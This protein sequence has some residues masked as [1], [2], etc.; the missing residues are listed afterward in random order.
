MLTYNNILI[1]NKNFD[2]DVLKE[3]IDEKIIEKS[4][5][6]LT[7]MYKNVIFFALVCFVSFFHPFFHKNVSH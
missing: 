1:L 3:Y 5:K 2:D 6:K 7:K 4:F